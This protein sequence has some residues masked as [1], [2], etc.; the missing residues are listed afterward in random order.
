MAWLALAMY[1]PNKSKPVVKLQSVQALPSYEEFVNVL[2]TSQD[3]P[4]SIVQLFWDMGEKRFSVSVSNRPKG[5]PEWTLRSGKEP[6]TFLVWTHCSGDVGLIFNLAMT[7]C[8]GQQMVRDIMEGSSSFAQASLPAVE[9]PLP[10]S[11]PLSAQTGTRDQTGFHLS[12]DLTEFDLPSLCQTISFG[13]K[14]GRLSIV[15]RTETADIFFVD[16]NP[17]HAA[18]GDLQGSDAILDTLCWDG[19]TF[20]FYPNDRTPQRTVQK[21]LDTMLMEGVALIDYYKHLTSKSGLKMDSYVLPKYAEIKEADFELQLADSLPINMQAQKD[22][23]KQMDQS[24]TLLDILR[25]TP[26]NRAQWVPILFNLVTSDLVVISSRPG[27]GAK[28]ANLE[29]IGVDPSVIENAHRSLVRTE[30]GIFSYPCFLYFLEQEYARY[31]K[32]RLPFSL[33]I[34]DV[35]I[36]KPSGFQP[37]SNLAIRQMAQ[38]IESIKRRF[39]LIGHFQTL[40]YVLML[41]HSTGES[42]HVVAQNVVNLLVNANLDGVQNAN[43]VVLAIGIASVPEDCEDLGQLLGAANTAKNHSKRGGATIVSFKTIVINSN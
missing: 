29:S 20:N 10:Y 32:T 24:T 19:G 28:K 9:E 1:R 25:S 2:Q 30:T 16:G 43:E 7:E 8:G 35:L 15:N 13:K 33:I 38:Q 17:V 37:L 40:E 5:D 4:D 14:T 27:V 22:F 31:Q 41:P 3:K 26:M 34:F 6:R 39:D 23:Y 42:A 36:R 12:G 18:C 11:P 21:R